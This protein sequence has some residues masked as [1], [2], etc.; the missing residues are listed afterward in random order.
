MKDK[1]AGCGIKCIGMA[2]SNTKLPIWWSTI[3][4]SQEGLIIQGMNKYSAMCALFLSGV[5]NK[6]IFIDNL[7]TTYELHNYCTSK[8]IHLIRTVRAQNLPKYLKPLYAVFKK[9]KRVE[10]NG[11]CNELPIVDLRTECYQVGDVYFI[12]VLDNGAFV[13]SINS[14]ELFEK[15]KIKVLSKLNEKQRARFNVTSYKVFK[16]VPFIVAYYNKKM[17]GV[18]VIDQLISSHDRHQRQYGWKVSLIF[19]AIKMAETT[20]FTINKR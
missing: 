8:G 10:I 16:L 2:D 5:S 14:V 18:D 20:P 11:Y 12:F 7:Y 17:N 1:P 19:T 3:G 9:L 15:G 6:C 13:I 4:L